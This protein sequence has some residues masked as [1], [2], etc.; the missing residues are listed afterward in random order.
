MK[1][2]GK[3]ESGYGELDIVSLTSA[4]DRTYWVDRDGIL[5]RTEFTRA[6]QPEAWV[7]R[8]WAV[9]IDRVAPDAAMFADDSLSRSH[10]PEKY[11]VRTTPDYPM[12]FS[13]E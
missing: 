12:E 13:D 6:G 1:Y 8:N 4:A 11:R 9:H 3:A 7:L 2:V 10:V 5:V